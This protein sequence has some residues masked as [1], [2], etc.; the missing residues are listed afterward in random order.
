[1]GYY[2]M[3]TWGNCIWKETAWYWILSAFPIRLLRVL[4]NWVCTDGI[5]YIMSQQSWWERTKVLYI[6]SNNWVLD[7]LQSSINLVLNTVSIRY[8][9]FFVHVYFYM[10][11]CLIKTHNGYIMFTLLIDIGNYTFYDIITVPVYVYNNEIDCF[12]VFIIS[13]FYTLS[14]SSIM[15]KAFFFFSKTAHSYSLRTC[16]WMYSIAK[17]ERYHSIH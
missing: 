2:P 12:Y 3:I 8:F 13:I 6:W 9:F 10:I 11:E 1:M 15:S 14:G 4:P 16:N 7:C 17:Y 5:W